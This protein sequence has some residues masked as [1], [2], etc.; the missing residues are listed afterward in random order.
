MDFRKLIPP[1]FSPFSPTGISCSC[2]HISGEQRGTWPLVLTLFR[3]ALM[4]AGFLL[5]YGLTST[6]ASGAHTGHPETHL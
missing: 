3:G 5:T 4:G 6:T 1:S 2:P